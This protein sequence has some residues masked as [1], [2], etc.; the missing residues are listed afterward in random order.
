MVLSHSAGT[1]FEDILFLLTA[2]AASAGALLLLMLVFSERKPAESAESPASHFELNE[3]VSRKRLRIVSFSCAVP[4]A[5][6][7]LLLCLNSTT[8][9]SAAR[10]LL[11]SKIAG[12]FDSSVAEQVEGLVKAVP[13]W[14]DPIFVLL[15][16]LIFF[17]PYVRLPFEYARNLIFVLLHFDARVDEVAQS[18]AE[19]VLKQMPYDAAE[20]ALLE[21]TSTRDAPVPKQLIQASETK[22]LAYQLLFFSKSVTAK[23]GLTKGLSDILA[24]IKVDGQFQSQSS[25]SARGYV[26]ASLI[27]YGIL[28]ASYVFFAPLLAPWIR[29]NGFVKVV[30]QQVDWPMFAD[31]L[32]ISMIQRT[33][34]FVIPLA[35]GMS[36]FATWRGRNPN[37][38]L[39]PEI[40]LVFSSQF[41]FALLVNVVVAIV[42]IAQRV[43]GETGGAPLTFTS[44]RVWSDA[45]VYS[46]T[47]GIALLSWIFCGHLR[48][49]ATGTII[50]VGMVA[51]VTFAM[52]GFLYE[53]MA[54]R[55]D[56]YY[57]HQLIL[58]AFITVSYALAALVAKDV[59]PPVDASVLRARPQ[60]AAG[61]DSLTV[62]PQG[63]A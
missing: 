9:L 33:L 29:S 50:V 31:E 52:C 59:F 48:F 24:K 16:S 22:I 61:R 23:H 1:T 4:F 26:L 53:H 27:F 7:V 45:F 51:A 19:A 6:L 18:A 35:F 34:S 14:L 56:G 15:A 20:R 13:A 41:M 25:S 55:R 47:P 63:A 57:W 40:V 32:A 62:T 28:C 2:L 58:G 54:G 42:T 17:A 30:L 11:S 39:F 49:K 10:Q 21:A 36:Y 38:R 43:T 60:P 8:L 46:L 5:L 44:V 12:V 37:G 3:L